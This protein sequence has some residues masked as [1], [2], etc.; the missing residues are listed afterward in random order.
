MEHNTISDEYSI[1]A[2]CNYLNYCYDNYEWSSY[3]YHDSDEL[4]QLLSTKKGVQTL[5]EEWQSVSES[6]DDEELDESAYKIYRHLNTYLKIHEQEL[7]NN[8]HQTM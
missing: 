5:M 1:E 3:Y 8:K 6:E 7:Q 4:H 2:T